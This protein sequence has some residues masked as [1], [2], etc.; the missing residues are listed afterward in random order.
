MYLAPEHTIEVKKVKCFFIEINKTPTPFFVNEVKSAGKNFILSFDSVNTI[1]EAKR[2]VNCEI[3]IDKKNIVKQKSQKDLVGYTLKDEKK[4]SLGL[5]VE[6]VD[7]PGQ[8]MFSLVVNDKEILLPFTED[9]IKKVDHKLK[10]IHYKA[11]EG[12]IDIYLS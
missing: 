5:V 1:E 8:R 7:M 6:I 11:P 12:L 2:I 9:L 3:W 10:V 4:G